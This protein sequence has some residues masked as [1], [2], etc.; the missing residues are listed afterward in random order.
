MTLVVNDI[1]IVGGFEK[2]ENHQLFVNNFCAL[3]IHVNLHVSGF[4]NPCRFLHALSTIMDGI[5]SQDVI[6]SMVHHG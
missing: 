2:K 6:H 5:R 3:D 4:V 1:N